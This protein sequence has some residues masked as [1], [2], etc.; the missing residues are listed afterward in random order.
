MATIRDQIVETAVA[1]GYGT[2]SDYKSVV[3][4]DTLATFAEKVKEKAASESAE[5]EKT[6]EP[7]T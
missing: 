6:E 4:A 2:E 3:I 1:M 7:I 5:E